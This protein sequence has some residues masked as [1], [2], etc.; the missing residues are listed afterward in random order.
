MQKGYIETPSYVVAALKAR[1]FALPE[2]SRCAAFEDEVSS[3]KCLVC[4]APASKQ[5]MQSMV[6]AVMAQTPAI[7]RAFLGRLEALL[8]STRIK[9]P[10]ISLVTCQSAKIL[11]VSW[12]YRGEFR[13]LVASALNATIRSRP[14][15]T[16]ACLLSVTLPPNLGSATIDLPAFKQALFDFSKCSDPFWRHVLR[17]VTQFKD[18]ALWHFP[19]GCKIDEIVTR[20][21]VIWEVVFD[22][23]ENLERAHLLVEGR[24]GS[25]KADSLTMCHSAIGSA[26]ETQLPAIRL[27]ARENSREIRLEMARL[28]QSV[29]VFMDRMAADAQADQPVNEADR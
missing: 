28:I 14:L 25:G 20:R 24:L 16:P 9:I 26:H 3:L 29:L 22:D 12:P 15:E 19:L 11:L 2:Q 21:G 1:S 13:A 4:N 7:V 10:R 5:G 27:L 17:R 8:E 23:L 18:S 6:V